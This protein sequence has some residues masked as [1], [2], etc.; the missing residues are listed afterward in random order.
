[1]DI[2]AERMT[3]VQCP[4]CGNNVV[5]DQGKGRSAVCPVCH[6]N[7]FSGTADT[8]KTIHCPQCG[9]ELHTSESAKNYQCPVCDFAI[10]VQKEIEKQRLKDSNL[11]SVLK[12]EGDNET[13]VFKHPVEDFKSGSQLIVHESQEAIFFRDGVALDLFVP[14][15]YTLETQSLPLLSGSYHIP[16]A[17]NSAVFHAEV[18]FI[19]QTVQMGI[20]WGT[21]GKVR[22]FDPSSG[23]HVEIGASGEFNLKVANSRKVLLKLVGTASSLSRDDLLSTGIPESAELA[24]GGETL[25]TGV[26]VQN[27]VGGQGLGM[28][29]YFRAMIMT[30]VKSNL[31]RTIKEQGLSILEIDE[32][33]D[34]LSVALRDVINGYLDEYGLIMPEFFVARIVTPDDDPN[35]QH[36]RQ[37]YADRFLKVKEE[38]IKKAEAEAAQQ[39]KAVEAETVAK[40]RI[41]TAQGMA[42][43]YKLQAA[44]EA[45]GMQMKGYSYQQE[46][47]RKVGMEAMKNGIGGNGSGAL[48]DVAGLGIGLGALGSIAGVTKESLNPALKD[49]AGVPNAVPAAGTWDCPLCGRK[50]IESNF[51]PDCGGKRP[52]PVQTGVLWDCPKC[53]RK[54]I[55]SKFCPDC[56]YKRGSE[57]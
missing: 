21:D 14:G 51:C 39:R 32:H 31:A 5:Y 43:A 40:L 36:M 41:I 46:T 48:G 54:N 29:G 11:I 3:A 47:A 8:I 27:T 1:M 30:Q 57:L 13:F 18:Y 37:Q 7:I 38:E 12:Y 52:V 19:N 16:T 9:V 44:A 6:E 23:L 22:L 53:G 34:E 45:A 55:E 42:E 10:D 50:N 2:R 26:H 4:H 15:K 28:R 35:Y 25:T 49:L 24:D 20:K 17:D 33:L 56:G